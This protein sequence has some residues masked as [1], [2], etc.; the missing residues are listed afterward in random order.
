[1]HHSDAPVELDGE[2][3][4]HEF[5]SYNMQSTAMNPMLDDLS[6]QLARFVE[7]KGHKA[8]PIAASNIW[9]YT[10]YKDLKVN[11]APDMAHR[12]AAV[13]AGLGVIG[14]NG[15][16]LTPQF[17][18]RNRFVSVITDAELTPT[19]MYDG[20]ILCDQ[21]N[22]CVNN[23]P[24]DAFRKEVKKMNKIEIGGQVFEFPETNK[25]RC[26]WAENFDLNLAHKIPDVINQDVILQ[27]LDKYGEHKGELGFCLRFCMTPDAATTTPS[28]AGRRGAR[29]TSLLSRRSSCCARSTRS[30]TAIWLTCSQST[31]RHSSLMLC[32]S[33]PSCTCRTW[34]L[35]SP[36][37]S[38]ASPEPSETEETRTMS[39]RCHMEYVVY[40]VA[41]Y[42]D[43]AGLLEPRLAPRSKTTWSRRNW[44]SM[45]ATPISPR[46]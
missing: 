19:P 26:G 3:N 14:W 15:L 13:A 4:G 37:A 18:P 45:M 5:S 27:Y 2:P 20:D 30:A 42:L 11:F 31:A 8:L 24:T 1:M 40:Q 6:F 46:S 25:W 7:D 10:G 12:Y 21:C 39:E 17:G 23:C 41:R 34:R 22:E 44:A 29:R 32:A 16:C 28:T 33:S 36:S 35:L 43:I 9:R 38:S